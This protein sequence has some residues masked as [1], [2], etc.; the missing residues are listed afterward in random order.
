VVLSGF[1][2]GI[3]HNVWGPSLKNTEKRVE[4][5]ICVLH[6][7]SLNWVQQKPP[8]RVSFKDFVM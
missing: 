7:R 1:E 6:R 5:V 4:L 3:F 8:T 2:E